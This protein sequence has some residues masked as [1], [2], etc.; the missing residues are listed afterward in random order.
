MHGHISYPRL[1]H[2][3]S[4]VIVRVVVNCEGATF[5]VVNMDTNCMEPNIDN[6]PEIKQKLLESSLALMGLIDMLEIER[7][8][9][10]L[11]NILLKMSNSAV[12]LKQVLEKIEDLISTEKV[13]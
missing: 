1:F 7:E 13:K 5:T 6:T 9:G 11:D 10:N 12:E 8:F 4:T 3:G 2:G